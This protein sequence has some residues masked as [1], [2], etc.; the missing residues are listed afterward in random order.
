[1]TIFYDMCKAPVE[2]TK[3]YILYR[4]RLI[5]SSSITSIHTKGKRL[6]I[7][8]YRQNT[9]YPTMLVMFPSKEDAEKAF[10]GLKECLYTPAPDVPSTPSEDS[11][12]TAGVVLGVTL[13]ALL[14]YLTLHM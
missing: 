6:M 12:A 1:M 14:G 9:S 5:D 13:C 2:I 10:M 8:S 3:N 4:N 7:N 11:T